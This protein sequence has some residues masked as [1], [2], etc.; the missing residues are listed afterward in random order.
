MLNHY[1][2]WKYLL[3]IIVLTFGFIYAAPNLYGEDPAVQISHRVNLINDE[4]KQGI[5]ALLQSLN[6]DHQSV[7]L[8]DGNILC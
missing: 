3:L 5:T 6:I 4:E 7:E 8:G 1:P 2:A